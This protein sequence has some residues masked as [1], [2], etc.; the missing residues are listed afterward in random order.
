MRTVVLIIAA[1]IPLSANGA[2]PTIEQIQTA[3]ERT[4]ASFTS[5]GCTYISLGKRSLASD[6]PVTLTRNMS[7]KWCLTTSGLGN[8]IWKTES[9][10]QG[11]NGIVED[12][13]SK[14]AI[15]FKGDA[16]PLRYYIINGRRATRLRMTLEDWV[17]QDHPISPLQ[18]TT[19]YGTTKAS[20]LVKECGKVIGNDKWE[21]REVVVVDVTEPGTEGKEQK[22]LWIDLERGTVVRRLAYGFEVVRNKM[23]LHES[24]DGVEF[25]EIDKVWCPSKF[26][27]LT[28]F[29]GVLDGHLLIADRESILISKWEIDCDIEGD[30]DVLIRAAIMMK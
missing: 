17:Q 6:P 14:E 15:V 12:R 24:L 3:L 5:I 22:V 1:L 30:D 7:A 19:N 27:R 2:E 13:D 11:E 25:Q 21:D 28:H 18:M 23:E 10:Q 4:E 26:K 8:L 20:V 9:Q 16:E 29:Y